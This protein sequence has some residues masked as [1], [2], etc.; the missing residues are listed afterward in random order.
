MATARIPRHVRWRH[1]TGGFNLIEL[2]VVLAI[3]AIALA[4]GLPD[5]RAMLRQHQLKAVVND[6]HG[7]IELTR[8]QAM[9]RGGRV[10]L[11]PAEPGSGDWARGWVVFVDTDGDL[12]PGAADDIIARRGPV[13]R[14]VTISAAFTSHKAANYI[15]YNTAGRGCSA[16]SST[17]A[18]WGTFTV[19][20]DHHTRLITINMLGRARVCDPEAD[21]ANCSA[22]QDDP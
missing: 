3:A 7:A 4:V 9:S 17:A 12:V 11:A 18:R 13:A 21:G 15:A 20:Q 16:T 5:L 1:P 19:H 6:L 14:D 22:A 2:M 8:A 10:L